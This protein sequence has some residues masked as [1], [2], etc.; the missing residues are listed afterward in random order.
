MATP[1][2]IRQFE[3]TI[4]ALI[5]CRSVIKYNSSLSEEQKNELFG[6]IDTSVQFLQKR[7]A[8]NASIESKAAFSLSPSALEEIMALNQQ[9]LA[10][11]DEEDE[12]DTN[13]KTANILQGLFK[14]YT[15]LLKKKDG[16]GLDLFVARYNQVM[17]LLGEVQLKVERDRTTYLNNFMYAD[18]FDRVRGFVT[19]LY[20]MFT[21][22][23][24]AIAGIMEGRDVPIDTEEVSS[25]QQQLLA[26]ERGAGVTDLAGLVRVFQSHAHL[27]RRKG[28][29]E[30]RVADASAL[31]VLLE[32]H[33]DQ[34][35]EK[36]DEVINQLK[37]VIN[38]LNDLSYLVVD[39]EQASMQLLRQGNV[40]QS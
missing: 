31:L 9:G 10:E 27:N 25:A 13:T 4:A 32:D 8:A 36:R 14:L 5:T 15:A 3:Q 6:D 2:H 7:L 1:D 30:M 16:N 11:D 24:T 26:G 37:N 23:A 29:M 28:P 12:G 40:S 35:V 21:E 34:H 22:F 19:D 38:L 20:T 17:S 18:Q 39:Y 33:L